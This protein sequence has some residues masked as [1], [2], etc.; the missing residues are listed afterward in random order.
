MERVGR[1]VEVWRND[2][3]NEIVISHPAFKKA[4][5]RSGQI[6][7]SARHA[8]HLAHVLI[9]LAVDAETQECLGNG[10]PPRRKRYWKR[11]V[12]LASVDLR[13]TGI[14]EA[15]NGAREEACAK[16]NCESAAAVGA[17]LRAKINDS[18]SSQ[19][20]A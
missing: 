18:S 12:D 4:G 13:E 17:G 1:A 9:E 15:L 19:E 8:R 5:N 14:G 10:F 3:T 7:F 16:A 20:T 11:L 6:A 2:D